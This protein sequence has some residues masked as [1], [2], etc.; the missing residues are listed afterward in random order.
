M[1]VASGMAL[2]ALTREGIVKLEFVYAVQDY[3]V[4]Q[5]GEGEVTYRDGTEVS[6][7]DTDLSDSEVASVEMLQDEA[8]NRFTDR[9]GRFVVDLA[10]NRI[11]RVCGVR[12]VV[13]S[14]TG[15]T[16]IEDVEEEAQTAT[17]H[18]D[19]IQMGEARMREAA[20]GPLARPY[21]MTELYAR[22]NGLPWPGD[23][24]E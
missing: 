9:T 8:A 12:V 24:G 19:A 18:F 11:T 10:Q 5:Y 13:V 7:L 1:D 4:D 6:L 23:K 16:D 14:N 15:D 20:W 3:G 17:L 2:D 22:A 21:P